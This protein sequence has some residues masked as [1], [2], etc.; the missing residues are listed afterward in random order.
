MKYQLIKFL[1]ACWLV[2]ATV[3]HN[4]AQ[5]GGGVVQQAGGSTVLQ[6]TGTGKPR[7]IVFILTDD[8]RYDALGFLKSQ[9]FIQTP[10]LNRLAREGAYL[11]NAFVTTAL[12]S[13]SRASILT[14]LYAH[15]HQVID[16]NNA[17]SPQ[18]V[19]FAQYLQ[20]A[21]YQTG[22]IGKWHMGG[23]SD[24]PP[25]RGFNQWVSF[26][27]QGSYLPDDRGL[28]VNGVKT[29]QK[30]YIT[31]EL[32]GYALDWLKT[33]DKKKPFLLYLSHKGVHSNFT[34][35]DKFMNTHPKDVFKLPKTFAIGSQEG[36]PMWVQNQRNSWHGVDFPYHS[37]LNI[38]DYY[39]R[40]AETLQGVDESVGDVMKYLKDNGLLESTLIVYMGD[41]GFLFG[42]HGLIDKRNAYE[43]SMRV[44]M[45]AYCP[46]LI[47]PGTVIKDVVANI[48]VAPTLLSVAGLQAPAY[49]DGKSFLPQLTG[50]KIPWRD[51]LLYE[52]YW[53]RNFPHTPTMHALRG[54]K[55]KYIHYY[56]IWDTDELYDIESDP[57]EARNLIT[58]TA[59]APVVKQM[60]TQ[61]FA[62]LKQTNGMYMPLYQ[63]V[64]GQQN[65][66]SQEGS[67]E[68]VFPDYLKVKPKAQPQPDAA[69]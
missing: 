34:P 12:C 40:Y 7:N 51:G 57:Q 56:G 32:T 62:I 63:D 13:P 16:N 19:F 4:M 65:K 58:E 46:Q 29:P 59:L 35:P 61:L 6:K 21:G 60:N 17:V 25:Q 66:R 18:L 28:N 47:K 67:K 39:K 31:N 45:L 23:G 14:G 22:F 3:T 27:G 36:Q 11:P 50:Q 24:S 5:S 38:T 54:N 26:P 68:A 1:G 55:Y 30:G 2:C 8:H 49:M 64:G 53:E 42:E 10:N 33:L 15:K 52:Y 48:D 41:N 20:Q 44:P 37:F 9:T 43:E 69:H